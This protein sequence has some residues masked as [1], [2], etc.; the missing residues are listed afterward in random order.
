MRFAYADNSPGVRTQDMCGLCLMYMG[1][2][3]LEHGQ[4]MLTTCNNTVT[5]PALAE[6]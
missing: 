2:Q 1:A 4:A 3:A 5:V 6:N